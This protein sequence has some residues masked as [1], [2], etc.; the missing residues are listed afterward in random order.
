MTDLMYALYDYTRKKEM[1][2]Y[3]LDEEYQRGQYVIGRQQENL[4][5]KHPEVEDALEKLLAEI[6]LHHDFRQEAMFQAAL[7]LGQRL[8]RLEP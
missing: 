8:S 6:Y 2:K 7:F 5:K 3:L 1:G 4:L